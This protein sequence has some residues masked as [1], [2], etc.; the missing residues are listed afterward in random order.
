M[1]QKALNTLKTVVLFT[2]DITEDDAIV[3]MLIREGIDPVTAWLLVI[4]H[5]F[6]HITLNEKCQQR[7]LDPWKTDDLLLAIDLTPE[8]IKEIDMTHKFTTIEAYCDAF[9]AKE[10]KA[11]FRQE[12][13]FSEGYGFVILDKI[14]TF[15]RKNSK[16]LGWLEADEYA[17]F[18][19]LFQMAQQKKLMEPEEAARFC[20][21]Q[22]AKS[23]KGKVTKLALQCSVEYK[24]QIGRFREMKEKIKSRKLFKR[25]DDDHDINGP[26]NKPK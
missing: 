26:P 4:A 22:L 1:I 11:Q 20:L 21:N 17:T 15:R 13:G 25:D 18:P 12:K 5:E 2:L 8:E 10:C 6:G 3:R 24:V 9:L 23:I 7:Q 19:A 14:A 16:Q